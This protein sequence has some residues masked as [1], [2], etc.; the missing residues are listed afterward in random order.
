MY[1]TKE[2][3]SEKSG[4]MECYLPLQHTNEMVM[5]NGA[6]KTGFMPFLKYK[7]LSN[8]LP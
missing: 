2:L 8:I 4:K 3:S 5:A 6:R 7:H 1:N